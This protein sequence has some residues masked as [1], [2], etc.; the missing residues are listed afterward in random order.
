MN[1]STNVT[2]PMS[3]EEMVVNSNSGQEVAFR[4]WGYPGYLTEDE[5]AIYEQFSKEVYGRSKDFRD[6]VF[7]FQDAYENESYA[8][9]RWLRARKYDITNTIKMVEEAT[10]CT[11]QPRQHDFYPSPSQALGCDSSLYIKQYPQ[12]YYGHAKNGCPVFYSKPALLNIIA[13]ESLTS[14]SNLINFHWNAMMHGFVEK[15]GDQYK[16]SNGTFK[17]Y[18]CVCILDLKN[19]TA[20]QLSKRPLKLIKDQSAIDSLCFPETLNHMSVVNAPAFF[21]LTWKLIR[22]WIDQRTADKVSVIGSNKET[23]LE[24]LTKHIDV[25]SLASDYGGNGKSVNEVLKEE[26]LSQSSS[27]ISD[28]IAGDDS[29]RVENKETHLMSMRS[30]KTSE[31]LISVKEG[32]LVKILLFTRFLLGGNLIIQD[33][34]GITLPNIPNGGICINHDGDTETDEKELPTKYE[35]EKSHGITLKGAGT[36][37]VKITSNSK[38]WSHT[39]HILLSTTVFS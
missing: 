30:G 38:K 17:R 34:N 36:Y 21:T 27:E 6:T 29:L 25:D 20:A 3:K 5:F 19:L 12:V 11:A 10:E 15:L 13:V 1:D 35:L 16:S 28:S 32:Q 39:T 33:Q 14:L 26:M 8:L 9:C 24:H 37:T 7:S 2:R 31:H 23:L 18:E 22:S 4:D